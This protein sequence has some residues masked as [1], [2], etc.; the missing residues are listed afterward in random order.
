MEYFQNGPFFPI[1]MK[2]RSIS[3]AGE[4][5]PSVKAQLRILDANTGNMKLN[6]EPVSA[7]PY[8]TPG[9]SSIAIG[10][11]IDISTLPDGPYCLQ[12]QATDSAGKSTPWRT[13]NFVVVSPE[14]S[15]ASNIVL[16]PAQGNAE[17]TLNIRALDDHGAPVTDLTIPDFQVLDGDNPQAITALML[18]APAPDPDAP[19]LSMTYKLVYISQTPTVNFDHLRV[20]CTR[21]NVRIELQQGY[22]DTQH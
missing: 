12:V 22:F 17:V 9:S 11:G 15:A 4:A 7:A 14:R 20:L 1:A 16:P 10:R 21:K 3:F 13:A 19:L 2:T 8:V 5:A 6:F 18:M